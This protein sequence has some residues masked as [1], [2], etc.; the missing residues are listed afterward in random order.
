MT[1]LEI[2]LCE[3]ILRIQ[4][5][6]IRTAPAVGTVTLKQTVD[7]AALKVRRAIASDKF[8]SGVKPDFSTG[9]C[10]STTAGYGHLD[11]NGY[12]Q[13]PLQVNQETYVASDWK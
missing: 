5:T 9:I 2:T 10:G 7:N 11:Q 3:E 1:D 6:L 12:F 4:S 8:N 13:F